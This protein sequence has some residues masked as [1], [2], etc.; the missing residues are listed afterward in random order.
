VELTNETLKIFKRF[1]AVFGQTYTR[2]LDLQNAEV[3]AREA[4]I[5]L[6]LERVRARTM[7]M[8]HSDELKGAAAL[9]LPTSKII[10][11]AGLQLRI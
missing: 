8:Q 10:R 9:L 4:E 11:G 3:L 1:A 7:A 5:E 2:F 6:A